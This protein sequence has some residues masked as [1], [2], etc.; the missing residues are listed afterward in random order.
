MQGGIQNFFRPA[1]EARSAAVWGVASIYAVAPLVAT[2]GNAAFGALFGIGAAMA[3]WRCYRTKQL[4]DFKVALT[5]RSIDV[6]PASLLEAARKNI[7]DNLWLGWGFRWEPRHAQLAHEVL[8]RN[9]AEIYPPQ[10]LLR[11]RGIKQDPREA[12]GIPWIQGLDVEKDVVVPFKALEGHT[13]IIAITGAIKTTLFKLLVYQFAS[14]GDIVIALDPKGD[15]DFENICRE[16][17]AAL[18]HPE[19][20]AKFHPA[21]PQQSFRFDAL[22]AWDRETQVASRIRMIMT[23]GE[24]DN[25]VSFVWMTVTHIV[26][27]LKRIGN[28]VTIATLLDHVQSQSAAETLAEKVLTAYLYENVPH[29][30]SMIDQRTKAI[31][32]EASKKQQKGKGSQIASPRLTAMA[33]YFKFEIPEHERPREISGLIAAL[34]ANREWFA[35]MI[36]SLTPILTKLSAGDLGPLLS[37]DYNDIRDER[38]IYNSRKLIEGGYVVYFGLDALSDASV[39]EAIAAMALADL[40]GTAGEIYNYEDPNARTRKIHVL[41][42]E[43]G[44]Q[45]CEAVI[46]LANKARGAGFV[47]YLAGQTVSDLIVKMGDRNKALRVLGN[48]NNTFVGATSDADTLEFIT[49]KLGKTSVVEASF[50]HGA[51]QKT[52]DAGME[53]SANRSVSLNAKESDL[54][55][56]NL[57]MGLP[58]LQYYAIVN[59][60]QVYKGRIP[61]LTLN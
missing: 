38:P 49:S 37:P 20:F 7:G 58:D 33:E 2:H 12:K 47:L 59:R 29:V 13:A 8:K 21:F 17:P 11:L 42:D 28:R 41:I 55:P 1:F 56:Q 23:A 39:A 9:M 48:M 40:A 45:V 19:R 5:G 53:Y 44:D 43:W 50:G 26:G 25:F 24:D 3:C 16:V 34:E 15:K 61:V 60:S 14:R 22:A 30:G 54:V 10:W 51:G 6:I 27:C 32:G 18:G 36:I 35:K 4:W 57:V 46:Q 31:E 52:E